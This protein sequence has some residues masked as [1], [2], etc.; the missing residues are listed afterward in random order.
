M[1]LQFRIE[2]YYK[3]LDYSSKAKLQG[4]RIGL[5]GKR[6]FVPEL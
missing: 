1:Y 5:S 2:L 6:V 3:L 4:L